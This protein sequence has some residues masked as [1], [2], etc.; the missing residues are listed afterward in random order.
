MDANGSRNGQEQM[1]CCPVS[2]IHRFG[3]LLE[4]CTS[5]EIISVLHRLEFFLSR[6]LIFLAAAMHVVGLRLVSENPC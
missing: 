3:H 4:S 5:A 1:N 2:S 6:I